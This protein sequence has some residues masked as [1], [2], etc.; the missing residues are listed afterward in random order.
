MWVYVCVCVCEYIFIPGFVVVSFYERRE[1]GSGRAES[2]RVFCVQ[3]F[4][5][6]LGG[7]RKQKRGLSLAIFMMFCVNAII[8]V[9]CG[10]S[11]STRGVHRIF[12]QIVHLYRY[13][14]MRSFTVL[15]T[16][17]HTPRVSVYTLLISFFAVSITPAKTSVRGLQFICLLHCCFFVFMLERKNPTD[18]LLAN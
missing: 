12:F 15:L 1:G 11:S 8:N 16:F 5:F 14:S 7:G 2:E 18:H 3:F 13:M 9:V 4:L 6:F 17:R 10:I